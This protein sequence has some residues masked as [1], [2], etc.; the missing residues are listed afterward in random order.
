MLRS[1]AFN[2]LGLAPSGF[3]E[4]GVTFGAVGMR[5]Q[6]AR[7]RDDRGIRR[8]RRLDDT[9]RLRQLLRTGRTRLVLGRRVG[10]IDGKAVG[11][12]GRRISSR[13]VS[14]TAAPGQSASS[15]IAGPSDLAAALWC[16]LVGPFRRVFISGERPRRSRVAHPP[17]SF[18]KTS[19]LRAWC[20]REPL[21]KVKRSAA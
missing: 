10:R 21:R 7:R 15:R 6:F 2:P 9:A 17:A 5:S 11:L 18:A 3:F 16:L 20:R 13:H 8:E 1:E 4:S 14:A 12:A 19:L